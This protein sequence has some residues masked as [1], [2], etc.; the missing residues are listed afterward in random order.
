MSHTRYLLGLADDALIYA[1]RLGE[2]IS[3]SPQIEQ[4]MAFG[5]I[6]LDQLGQARALY[7]R[8]G[9]LD[10][11]GRDED[12]YAYLRNEREFRSVHLVEAERGDF[13]QE[14]G[15]LLW[16]SSYQVQLYAALADSADEVVAGVAAKAIKEVDYHQDHAH[17]WVLRLGDGTSVSHERMQS[18]LTW[19]APYVDE[20]FF[21]D[22]VSVEA[23]RDGV[24]V[25]PSELRAAASD[26]VRSVV[27][28]ATLSMPDEPKWHARGGRDGIHSQPMGY[29]LAELQHIR[30]SYPEATRW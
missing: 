18:A 11:T 17:Q 26:F 19:V 15:R 5:N 16:F 24:G 20:L 2:W 4:D 7:T 27:R 29:L 8:V 30:R 28:D 3:R 25:L 9:Q 14:M 12:A 23:A 21:D 6:A 1:Q 10:G 22:A 13:A